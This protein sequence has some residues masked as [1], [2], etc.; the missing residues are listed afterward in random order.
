LQ[1][2]KGV[3]KI[4]NLVNS[5]KIFCKKIRGNKRNKQQKINLLARVA[6]C[7]TDKA[8]GLYIYHHVGKR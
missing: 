5:R 3:L 1:H 2:K 4:L 7:P 6:G 8:S